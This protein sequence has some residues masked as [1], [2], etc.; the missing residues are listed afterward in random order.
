M[1]PKVL[2]NSSEISNFLL[3]DTKLDR[4]QRESLSAEEETKMPHL[5]FLRVELSR[6][7]AGMSDFLFRVSSPGPNPGSKPT[8]ITIRGDRSFGKQD[9]CEAAAKVIFKEM[10]K[11]NDKTFDWEKGNTEYLAKMLFNHCRFFVSNVNTD[12]LAFTTDALH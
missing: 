8:V 7:R 10:T 12:S 9:G 2:K 11:R 5:A 6:L 3:F 4:F 1:E